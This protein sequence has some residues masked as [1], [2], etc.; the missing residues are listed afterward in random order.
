MKAIEHQQRVGQVLADGS[1]VS[2]AHV[3]AG[4]FHTCALAFAH[5]ILEE[6]INGFTPFA[7]SNPNDVMTVKIVDDGEIAV[8]LFV[9]DLVDAEVLEGTYVMAI[10]AAG[11][12]PM[13]DVGYGGGGD[14]ELGGGLDLGHDFAQAHE[15]AFEAQGVAAFGCCPGN[16]FLAPAVGGTMDLARRIVQGDDEAASRNVAP[17]AAIACSFS[18]VLVTAPHE[19][20]ATTALGTTGTVFVRLYPEVEDSFSNKQVMVGNNEFLEPEQIAQ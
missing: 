4:S 2:F 14:A 16:V 13:K 6:S 3:T 8:T 19:G 17:C 15:L 20:A 9:R 18:L 7:Y 11:D 5:D 12:D 10:A 1:S